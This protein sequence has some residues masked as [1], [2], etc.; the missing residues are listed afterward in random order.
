[1]NARRCPCGGQQEYVARG[2]YVHHLCGRVFVV[3]GQR[4]RRHPALCSA[5]HEALDVVAELLR[6]ARVHT[7][8]PL[9][10]ESL[11]SAERLLH[12]VQYGQPL[13]AEP[14]EAIAGGAAP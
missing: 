9:S 5:E 6:R 8:H 12:T 11:D 3:Q 7:E 1:M 10:R 13:G 14:E 2:V 4:G